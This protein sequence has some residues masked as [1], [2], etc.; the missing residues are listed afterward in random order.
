M[1]VARSNAIAELTVDRS[2]TDRASWTARLRNDAA[3]ARHNQSPAQRLIT[4]V[5]MR[6]AIDGGALA[7]ALTGS[8]ARNRRTEVSDLDYHVVG[9]RPDV[10]DL[11]GDVDVYAG[12]ADRFWQKLRAGDDFVQWT[13]RLGCILFDSGIMRQGLGCIA[14]ENLWP[15]ADRKLTRVPELAHLA[16]RLI[17]MGDRDAGQDQVRATLTASARALLLQAGVFPLSRSELPTQLETIGRHDLGKRLAE[18]IHRELS[19]E[20]LDEAL[21]PTRLPSL[22]RANRTLK[23]D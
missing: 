9:D 4:E 11:P 23:A 7:V 5:V 21:A 1:N 12:T 8:T 13:L 2:W 10:A 15:D 16:E 20:E 22:S 6:R 18:T 3:R 19:L 17:N 14:A